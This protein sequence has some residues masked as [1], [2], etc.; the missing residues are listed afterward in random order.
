MKSWTNV[1]LGLN[2][3]ATNSKKS[4]EFSFQILKSKVKNACY[5]KIIMVLC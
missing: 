5:T 4:E 1:K 2:L 3:T